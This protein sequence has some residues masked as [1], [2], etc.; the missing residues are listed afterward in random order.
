MT[1]FP[2]YCY[3]QQSESQNRQESSTRS[4][5]DAVSVSRMAWAKGVL[6]SSN[7]FSWH[8]TASGSGLSY[9]F[10]WQ[11]RDGYPPLS[12]MDYLL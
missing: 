11:A 2:T 5:W 1:L 4:R 3:G 12:P 6:A 8:D 10:I 7:P 9:S